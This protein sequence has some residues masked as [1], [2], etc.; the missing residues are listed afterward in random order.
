VT[1]KVQVDWD[2]TG[3][4]ATGVDD[5]TNL[6]RPLR[7]SVAADYGR[8]QSTALAPT[9]SGRGSLTLDNSDRRFSPRNTASPL[10]GFIKPARPVKIT[11]TIAGTDYVLFIGHTDDSPINPDVDA[12]TVSLSLVDNLA[13]FRGQNISTT[14]YAGIR[15]GEAIGHILDACNWSTTLRDLD[16]GATVIPYW[17]EDNTDALDALE[18]V[19]R[20]EGPPSLLTVGTSGEI[21]FKDRHHRLLDAPSITSQATWRGGAGG[22][23][24]IMNIPFSYDE[25]WRNIVNTGTVDVD[26]RQPQPVEAVWTAEEI[27]SVSAGE[28]KLF[29]ASTT[30]PFTNTIP[31]VSGT[32]YTVL[33]G[34]VTVSLVRSSGASAV[35]S[36]LGGPG[37]ATVQGL[38][39][40]AQ[41]VSVNYSV[42]VSAS[43]AGS[44][45][46]YGQRSYPN[47]LPWCNPYDAQ[48]VLAAAV[49]QRAQ[50]APIVSVR[51]MIGNNAA[52]GAAILARDLSD[53]V[54][55]SETE[56][57]LND[58]FYIE[59]FQ[60][61]LTSQYDH[62][63]TVG[64]E[65]AP[66]QPSPAFQLDTAGAG[67][68]QGKLVGGY[69]NPANILILS[70]TVSGHRLGEG[71]LAL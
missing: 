46:D 1:Y 18:K 34:T 8:D 29:T 59:S 71:V 58:D 61:E 16:A 38:Q 41:P 65:M 20:S 42:Q 49:A 68:D 67:A 26:V 57:A 70:S 48:A 25:A 7:G 51:F 30:D 6:V 44:I 52:R 17:W 12:Q 50:P 14:L 28:L 32:D 54:T 13:D 24:P 22:A 39:L 4:G 53:R 9:V 15:T 23:E 47:D 3:Y 5:V 31:P 69:S 21:I 19:L 37:G 11:R 33:S 43:D 35:I 55:I 45:S 56:T 60:H 36:V 62:S 2:K 66:V 63:V 10:Y 64:L 27:F 40:R